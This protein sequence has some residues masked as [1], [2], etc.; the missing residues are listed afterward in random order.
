MEAPASFIKECLFPISVEELNHIHPEK[1]DHTPSHSKKYL[2]VLD[3]ETREF[4][5]IKK[6]YKSYEKEKCVP[7]NEFIL[8]EGL[9]IF[10]NYCENNK[11]IYL[12]WRLKEDRAQ[13]FVVLLGKPILSFVKA[14]VWEKDPRMPSNL[15]QE[16]IQMFLDFKNFNSRGFEKFIEMQCANK[17]IYFSVTNSYDL[18]LPRPEFNIGLTDIYEGETSSKTVHLAHFFWSRGAMWFPPTDT[19]ERNL[20]EWL[21]ITFTLSQIELDSEHLIPIT[22]DLENLDFRKSS[23][24]RKPELLQKV[25]A[26]VDKTRTYIQIHSEKAMTYFDLLSLTSLIRGHTM[27][28]IKDLKFKEFAHHFSKEQ[29]DEKKIKSLLSISS[30]S[31]IERWNYEKQRYDEFIQIQDLLK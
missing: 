19:F 16:F 15:K 6:N 5:G 22:I 24:E 31:N 20:R 23:L 8:R 18:Q 10:F 26:V 7:S 9:F 4:L 17:R 3:E 1:K 28:S 14:I 11:P 27:E 13:F 2:S 30:L 29:E 25:Q 12:D 21:I